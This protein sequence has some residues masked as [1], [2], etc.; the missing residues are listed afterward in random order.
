MKIKIFA[1]IFMVGAIFGQSALLRS[2]GQIKMQNQLI[3]AQDGVTRALMIIDYPHHELHEGNH[4]NIA[5]VFTLGST[6]DT[7][8]IVFD[9]A[10]TT[11]RSHMVWDFRFLTAGTVEIIEGGEFVRSP[12]AVT[13]LNNDRNSSTVSVMDTVFV[14]YEDST[15]TTRYGTTRRTHS[16]GAGQQVGGFVSRDTEWIMLNDSLTVFKFT[17]DANNNKIEWEF[18]WYEHTSVE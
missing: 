8:L 17:T 12:D 3:D 4:F 1:L 14:V 6:N 13:P 15:L 10:D 5:G 16:V 18:E 2:D 11:K 9:V 7:S